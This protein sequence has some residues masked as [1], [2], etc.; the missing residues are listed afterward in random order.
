MTEHVVVAALG[1]LAVVA[2]GRRVVVI[3]PSVTLVTFF[4]VHLVSLSD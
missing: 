4:F 1:A 3:D 2:R